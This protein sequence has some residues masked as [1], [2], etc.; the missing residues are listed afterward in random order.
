MAGVIRLEEDFLNWLKFW[1]IWFDDVIKRENA[2]SRDWKLLE[3]SFF[4][5]IN[6][7]S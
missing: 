7:D 2:I 4:T 1:A 6:L 5:S 3:K